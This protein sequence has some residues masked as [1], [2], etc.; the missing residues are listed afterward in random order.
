M[1]QQVETGPLERGETMRSKAAE[2]L[3]ELLVD[4]TLVP[5][6]RVNEVVLAKTLAISR[7]PLREAIQQLAGEGLL[8]M[9]EGRGARVPVFGRDE[10]DAIYVVREALEGMAARLAAMDGPSAG[11]RLLEILRK[12]GDVIERGDGGS[13]PLAVDLDIHS[14]IVEMS[15]NQILINRSR[16]LVLQLRL[17]RAKSGH[18]KTRANQA[19][20][21]HQ[22]VVEA[23]GAGDGDASEALMREHIREAR[24]SAMASVQL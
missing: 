9:S 20:L 6:T 24:M 7:G 12:T 14:A 23:I 13:Y 3:R 11:A 2:T 19:F 8:N 15:G 1:V 5:G 22:R 4:G 16:E 10:V 17:V 18:S 21:E